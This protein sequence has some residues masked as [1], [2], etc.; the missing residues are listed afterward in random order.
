MTVSN[1]IKIQNGRIDARLDV[2]LFKKDD[3]FYAYSPALDLAGYGYNEEEAKDSFMVVMEDFFEF[4]IK[5]ETLEQDL[6]EHGWVK[7]SKCFEVP[8]IWEI[9]ANSS[10]RHQL[11]SSNFEKRSVHREYSYC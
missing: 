8:N 7:E 4:G 2:F 1:Y 10:E 6:T 11:E 9:L 5:R 3:I